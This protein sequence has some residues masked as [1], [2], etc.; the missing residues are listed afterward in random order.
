MRLE[1][2]SN[3]KGSL[4]YVL[5]SIRT[6]ETKIFQ[7]LTLKNEDLFPGM[8]QIFARNVVNLFFKFATSKN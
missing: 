3:V 5:K 1:V 4:G 2:Q 7:H 8:P 6:K